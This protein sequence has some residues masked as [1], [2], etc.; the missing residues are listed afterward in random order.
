MLGL[1]KVVRAVLVLRS[2]VLKYFASR[3]NCRRVRLRSF[4]L[5]CRCALA[6][7]EQYFVHELKWDALSPPPPWGSER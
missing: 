1:L 5:A 2:V 6:H 4:R 3:R 7:K